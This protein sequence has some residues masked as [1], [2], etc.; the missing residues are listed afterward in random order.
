ML[1]MNEGHQSNYFPVA[2]FEH[3]SPISMMN[4][5]RD[6]ETENY[7]YMKFSPFVDGCD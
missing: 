2:N 5:A 6:P 7:Y 4:G 1:A 3:K